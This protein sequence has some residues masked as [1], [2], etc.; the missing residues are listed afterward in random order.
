MIIYD[1]IKRDFLL[2]V[3]N[4]QIFGKIEEKYLAYIGRPHEAMK[5]S[6]KNSMQYMYKVLTDYTI[7]SNSGVSIEFKIPYTSCKIDFLLSGK[8]SNQKNTLII[9]E[10]KQ[11][12]KVERVDGQD[13]QVKTMMQGHNVQTNHP[14]YQAWSYASMIEDYNET[15]QTQQI[16]L[17]PCAYLHN[18]ERK[19]PEPLFWDNYEFYTS[20]A[21]VFM[22]GEIPKL[23]D[24][25]KKYIK[26]GDDKE[27]MYL[28]E[29]GKI[30]PSKSLQDSLANMLNGNP[31]FILIDE[32]KV[33]YEKALSFARDSQKDCKKRVFIVEGGPGTG[34]TVIA[35]NLLVQLTKENRVCQYVTKNATPR[36][37]Y[38]YKLS[39][40]FKKTRIDN[41]FKGSGSYVQSNENEFDVLIVDE[42]HRLNEKSGMFKN[43]GENQIKEIINAAKTTVFFIDENQKVDI[44]AIGTVEEIKKFAK[45][46]DAEVNIDKL[47]SQ[48]RCNGSD[49]Y[50]AWLD[51]VLG[52]KETANFDGFDM[53]YDLKVFDDPNELRHAIEDKNKL[54]NKSRIV[55]G[56]CWDWIASG[57]NRSDIH[58]INIPEYDFHMSW[59]LANTQTWAIDSE[60]V[61]EAG[62]IHTSQGLEFD[63][64]GVI[65]GSDMRFENE[66]IIAD[67]TKRA[68]TDFSLKGIKN[69]AKE[70]PEKARE[71][72]E[73]I[74]K[75][76]YRTLMTR[77]QKGCYIYCCDKPLAN[78]IKS[79]LSII[80]IKNR[81]G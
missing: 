32:Q 36:N 80:N 4:D 28:I 70:H 81:P 14:S 8:D 43:K 17:Y 23:R 66:K 75:N 53:A 49:G 69:L 22:Y 21:P 63:Y 29:N 61:K 77:G 73:L 9:I 50:L 76:T 19:D 62:C 55:A 54:N 44:R 12:E 18:Y 24:F 11:W 34:K 39:G 72:A 10:L 78:Y 31:E 57:K 79:R 27:T 15:V 48:F 65:F 40:D 56:Y 25:I 2:D 20:K 67:Y 6:W 13:A 16:R 59:N 58:D 51:D 46:L 1:S 71:I 64:I 68:K 52:I 3:E 60:S 41:L 37:V 7:P 45:K 26:Y 5:R 74:I 42:S 38:S 35:M 30:K 47:N 33:V